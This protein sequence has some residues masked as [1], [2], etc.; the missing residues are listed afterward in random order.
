MPNL[1][2]KYQTFPNAE[3]LGALGLKNLEAESL[4][5]SALKSEDRDH[6]IQ[7]HV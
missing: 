7:I 6:L 1:G 2:V 5:Q 3:R 4:L